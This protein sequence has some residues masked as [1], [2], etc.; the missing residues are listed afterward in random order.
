M[1]ALRHLL[2]AAVMLTVIAGLA[3]VISAWADVPFLVVFIIAVFATLANGLL[4][5]LEDDL[6]GGF[7]NPDGT[8]T[9]PY[10]QR[11]RGI[12]WRTVAVLALLLAAA[13]AWLAFSGGDRRSAVL[14]VGVAAT[15]LIAR[16]A[17]RRNR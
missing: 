5:T 16:F 11:L 12:V 8:D 13:F 3:A 6:P 10:V 4:A 15:L 1:D 2:P 17:F 9:P 7:N 14:A